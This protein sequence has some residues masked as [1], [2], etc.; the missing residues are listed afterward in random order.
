MNTPQ[1]TIEAILFSVRERGLGALDEP[2]T[3]ERLSRC[4][5]AAK[6]AIEQRITKLIATGTLQGETVD[7]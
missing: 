6:A 2:A 4:D 3:L 5:Q 1:S 7:D